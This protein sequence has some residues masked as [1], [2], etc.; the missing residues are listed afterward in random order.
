M[1]VQMPKDTD[2]VHCYKF[3]WNP[4]VDGLNSS[5]ALFGGV[6]RR[7]LLK[8]YG[9]GLCYPSTLIIEIVISLTTVLTVSG[10]VELPHYC[11]PP[12]LSKI[13]N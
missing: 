8:A 10:Y 3:R 5:G 13:R 9:E 12:G 4:T 11:I 7:N 1:P 2:F 6:L